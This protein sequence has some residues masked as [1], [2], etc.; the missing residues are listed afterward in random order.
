[1][2]EYYMSTRLIDGKPKKVIANKNG[3]L[4]QNITRNLIILFATV[5]TE[6]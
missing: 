2:T 1:M 4:E 5:Q 3:V 6:I